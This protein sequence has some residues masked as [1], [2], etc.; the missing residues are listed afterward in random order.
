MDRKDVTGV[1]TNADRVRQ[2]TDEEL[3]DWYCGGREPESGTRSCR[4]CPYDWGIDC[5]LKH[6]LRS[7]ADEERTG[8]HARNV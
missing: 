6:W 7:R 4:S 5:G 8:S 3:R 1:L 2:M